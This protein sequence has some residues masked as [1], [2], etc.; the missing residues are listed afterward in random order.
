MATSWQVHSSLTATGIISPFLIVDLGLFLSLV[1]FVLNAAIPLVV[2]YRKAKK[3]DELPGP[4]KSHWL[5]GHLKQVF[6]V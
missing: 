2:L 4:A 5:L 1:Y 6:I 3:L